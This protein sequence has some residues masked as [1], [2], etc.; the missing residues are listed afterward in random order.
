MASSRETG[1]VDEPAASRFKIEVDGSVGQL[2]YSEEGDALVLVHTEVP[3][4]IGGRGIAGLLVR[5]ALERAVDD[6]LVVVPRCPYARRWLEQHPDE[7]ARV[8][9]EWPSARGKR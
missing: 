1:V 9:I 8:A 2:I 4:E 5:A 3:D 7:A 6:D